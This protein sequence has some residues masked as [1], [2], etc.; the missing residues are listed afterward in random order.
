M[1]IFRLGSFRLHSGGHSKWK[2]DLDELTEEDIEVLAMLGARLV[3]P[4]GSIEA[5]PQGGIPLAWAL[6]PYRAPKGLPLIVDD[7]L[8]TGTSMES[9]RDGRAAKGLVAFAR[10]PLPRWV[11]AIFVYAGDGP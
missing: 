2:I 6:A 1:T 3:G 5:V 10:G 4:F 9:Q 7:V 8:T 11:K